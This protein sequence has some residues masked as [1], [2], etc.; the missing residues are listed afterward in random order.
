METC[1]PP[2]IAFSAVFVLLKRKKKSHSG[3]IKQPLATIA[4]SR[5]SL[6]G[7]VTTRKEDDWLEKHKH[8][9]LEVDEMK[10]ERSNCCAKLK[11][12]NVIS[13]HR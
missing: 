10:F 11:G 13:F 9:L 5:G 2:R 8:F 6:P 12:P 7:F 3:L 4:A 1:C